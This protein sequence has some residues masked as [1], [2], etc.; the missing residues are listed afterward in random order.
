MDKPLFILF[1]LETYLK[2]AGA[3]THSVTKFIKG[4]TLSQEQRMP[5]LSYTNSFSLLSCQHI[6]AWS[7][8]RLHPVLDASRTPLS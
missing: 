2:E 4:Y 3:E 5:T 1:F 6:D 8:S 7:G